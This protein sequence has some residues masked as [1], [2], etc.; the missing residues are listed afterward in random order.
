MQSIED[1]LHPDEFAEFYRRQESGP[2]K[3]KV[4]PAIADVELNPETA[5][6]GGFED[7]V[8]HGLDIDDDV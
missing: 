7:L 4:P 1:A 5:G 2:D 3:S 6:A 8:D